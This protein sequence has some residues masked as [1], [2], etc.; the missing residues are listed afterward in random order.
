MLTTSKISTAKYR[1]FFVTNL[2]VISELISHY[3]KGN[4]MFSDSWLYSAFAFLLAY[5]FYML[6]LEDF[7]L[8]FTYSSR[9]NQPTIDL[10]RLTSLFVISKV[11]TSYL[12]S[13]IVNINSLWI[14]KTIM[15]TGSYFITDIALADYLIKFNNHQLLFYNVTKMFLAEYLIVLFLYSKFT[16][17]DFIDNI[18]FLISYIFF[19]IITKKFI[20]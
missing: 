18:S 4:E 20:N 14:A 13:G 19:E 9:F 8:K 12:E 17:T 10:L 11:F 7:V 15:I 5:I 1:F 3:L 16:I 2:V 6:F